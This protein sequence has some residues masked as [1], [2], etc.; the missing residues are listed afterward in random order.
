MILSDEYTKIDVIQFVK[1]EC[2]GF[3][4]P[5]QTLGMIFEMYADVTYNEEDELSGFSR[6]IPIA[7][8]K[9]IHHSFESTN[10]CQWARSD[11]SY[12]GQKYIIIRPKVGGKVSAVKLDGLNKKSIKRKRGI[13]ADIRSKIEKEPCRILDI[14]SQIEVDHKDGHYDVL[15]NQD[16]N[17]QKE[18]DF[19]PL[20][21][22]ANDAKRCHC[23]EC[24]KTGK[25]YDA[26]RLG[27]KESFIVGTEDTKI[28]SG[29]YWYDPRRFNEVISKD[30]VKDK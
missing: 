21:K 12:L 8:L 15:S 3:N 25:R 18:S 14:H 27:Y 11:N 13:R 1:G 16:L 10:G 23:M 22:A 20:S 30:F 9:N 5:P 2:Q 26:K 28:C 29:C 6:E 4:L 17:T 19:Q 24:I 7:E